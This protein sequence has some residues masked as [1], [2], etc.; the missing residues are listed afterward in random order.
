MHIE[1]SVFLP[2]GTALL[3]LRSLCKILWAKPTHMLINFVCPLSSPMSSW[4]CPLCWE[5]YPWQNASW[6]W[7]RYVVHTL[8]SSLYWYTQFW[9][10]S[11]S[12]I[13]S[14]QI[15]DIFHSVLMLLS[16]LRCPA[17]VN[18]TLFLQWERHYIR[19]AKHVQLLA[20]LALSCEMQNCVV[21]TVSEIYIKQSGN[22]LQFITLEVY[23][24]SL[25]RHRHYYKGS[26]LKKLQN[27]WEFRLPLWCSLGLNSSG[28]LCSVFF[29]SCLPS[30][31]YSL[32]VPSPRGLIG[33]PETSANNHQWTLYKN[34][35]S[36]TSNARLHKRL[37]HIIW[38][39]YGWLFDRAL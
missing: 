23:R 2:Q 14:E 22:P 13:R 19:Y 21:C 16:W 24:S 27:L 6:G 10:F 9:K 39:K 33:F 17:F 26:Y 12:I 8:Y 11:S 36:K 32:L 5:D 7:F 18:N 30:F 20:L 34:W 25:S 29:G 3:T 31:L 1:V 35:R 28:C 4:S 37:W 15:I 38:K